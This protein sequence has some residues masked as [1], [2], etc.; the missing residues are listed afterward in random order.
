V[1]SRVQHFSNSTRDQ[2]VVTRGQAI[3]LAIG[4]ALSGVALAVL[5]DPRQGRRRRTMLRDQ[6]M[7]RIR[8]LGRSV[9]SLWRGAAADAYGASHRIVHLKPRQS[10]LPDDDETLRQRVESQLFRDRHIPKGN[11]NITAE[12]GTITL[13]GQ[14]ESVD[15][16]T[17]LED[18]VRHIHGV[19]GIENLVHPR[20]TPAPNKERSRMAPPLSS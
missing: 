2:H 5:G 1:R 11:L 6:S 10:N 12:H 16:I 18:R 19:R 13:R 9:R 7:A 14:L 8:R 15:E 3:W 4:C 20:G 17:H